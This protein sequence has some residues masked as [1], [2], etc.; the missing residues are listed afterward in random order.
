MPADPDPRRALCN[1]FRID[2]RDIHPAPGLSTPRRLTSFLMTRLVRIPW[3]AAFLTAGFAFPGAGGVARAG[4]SWFDADLNLSRHIRPLPFSLGPRE[5]RLSDEG[6]L[7][8]PW[9]ESGSPDRQMLGGAPSEEEPIPLRRANTAGPAS[10][11][12]DDP[13]RASIPTR[14]ADRATARRNDS[15][16]RY[17]NA[18]PWDSDGLVWPWN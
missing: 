7:V 17:D 11:L 3:L 15:D 12:D 16:Q 10:G 8:D 6:C 18:S 4:D 1:D 2:S 5:A 14:R 13:T 9:P